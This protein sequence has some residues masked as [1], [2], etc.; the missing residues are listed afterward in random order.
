MMRCGS[1]DDYDGPVDSRL[2]TGKNEGVMAG[3]TD[4]KPFILNHLPASHA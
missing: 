2:T 3:I 4:H 1:V